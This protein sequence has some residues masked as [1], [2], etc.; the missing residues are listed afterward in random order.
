MSNKIKIVAVSGSLRKDSY[1]TALIKA[2]LELKPDDMDIEVLDIS[3]IPMF[4]DDDRLKNIPESVKIISEII[5]SADGLLIA[6]PEYNYSI[7]GILKN[8]ID[9]VSK[10]STQ[11]LNE[12]PT[13]IMGA[14]PGALG[15]VRAQMHLRQIALAVN[16]HVLN[17]PEVYVTFANEKFDS[18]GKLIHEPT[19]EIIK[20]LLGALGDRINK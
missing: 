7:P 13:A 4:N 11:P 19:R 15:T 2:A 18:K 17:K 9:W 8:A 16:M 5:S 20:K 14:S 12:K 1:N 10:M 6:T 3:G